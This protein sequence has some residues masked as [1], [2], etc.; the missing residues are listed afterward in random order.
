MYL[1][2]STDRIEL[3]EKQFSLVDKQF[4]KALC[5][6]LFKKDYLNKNELS[7][8][9]DTSKIEYKN[10]YSRTKHKL[11]GIINYFP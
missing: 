6:V 3:T 2:S 10:G 8:L 5:S 4:I 7:I 1:S 9:V 11:Y